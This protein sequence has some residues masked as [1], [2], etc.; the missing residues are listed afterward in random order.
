MRHPSPLSKRWPI[1][2][3]CLALTALL[4]IGA[5]AAAAAADSEIARHVGKAEA[6]AGADLKAPLFL[7]R[8]DSLAVV[9]D[10][11]TTGQRDWLPPTRVFDNIFY[12]GNRFVG[13]FV[14]KTSAGLI[15]FD[16]TTSREDVEQHLLPG[17]AELGLDP[18]T[19]RYVIVTHGHWDHFGGAA[20]LQQTYGAKVGLSA[21]D[22][23]LIDHTP[24]D[25]P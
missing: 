25:S 1:V 14:I 13:V 19:I 10:T 24:A 7:C 5:S 6:L 20:Y 9:K 3:L 21:A 18:K 4:G 11:L 15:L 22:W 12:I 16:S 23:D 2:G 8:A 17:L